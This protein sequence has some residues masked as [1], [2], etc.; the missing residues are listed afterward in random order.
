VE[1]TG[2]PEIDGEGARHGPK[3]VQ[4]FSESNAL[5][6]RNTDPGEAF[7]KKIQPNRKTSTYVVSTEERICCVGDGVDVA[8]CFVRLEE[9]FHQK[10]IQISFDF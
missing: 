8:G 7:K 1:E 6:Y 5:Q 2:C 9:N 3:I 10:K 4:N